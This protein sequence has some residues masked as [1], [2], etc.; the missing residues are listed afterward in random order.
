MA[1]S[2]DD[3]N[4]PSLE[5]IPLSQRRELPP[6]NSTDSH[7]QNNNSISFSS[8][9][10]IHATVKN[11]HDSCDSQVTYS[12]IQNDDLG[13]ANTSSLQQCSTIGDVSV[14]AKV[15]DS[16]ILLNSVD[17]GGN[18]TAS[19]QLDF[20][21]LKVKEEI[22]E[23]TVDDLDHVVLKERQRMLLARRLRGLPSPAFEA[24]SECLFKNIVDQTVEKENGEFSSVDGK[25]TAARDQC[26]DI[27]EGKN[28]SLSELP[29]EAPSGSS[30][31]TE[32]ARPK[33]RR[34]VISAYSQE[35]DQ[36]V[37]SEAMITHFDSQEEQ[38][39]MPI[40]N[41]GPSSSACPTSVK[42]KDEP[43]DNSEIHNV[44]ENAMGSTSIK[45]PVVKNEQEVHNDYNDDQV[46]H[47]I[48][49]DRL[50]FLMSRED[51]SLSIPISYPVSSSNFSESA[52]P[53]R[54][55]CARK[56]KKTATNSIQ[57]ALQEDA[58][59][60]LEALLGEG[61]LV[62]EI[63]LYG[64]TENDEA[65]DESLCQDS[66]SE[67][68]AVIT[69][70]FSQRNSFIKFPVI[71]AAKGSRESYCLASLISLV[72]QT[73]HLKLQ[74][75]PVEWGWCRDLQSFIFVF[76]RHNRI[77]LERPEYGYATYFFELLSGLP[78]E[79]QIK[80]LVVAMK[81]TTCSRISIIENKELTLFYN[82]RDVT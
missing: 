24:N 7:S 54:I 37:K 62:D 9:P 69:K 29:H 17:N 34:P 10:P 71:R 38:G 35:Y 16:K 72:E 70:I 49:N 31:S 79:W 55:K 5:Y 74:K 48:L 33:S 32:H 1:C 68:E 11:E 46:E 75:W 3:Q 59:G 65:L 53:S 80:R 73:R 56:R 30:L 22:C 23:G 61:V 8:T 60:L 66:F 39:V 13:V 26:H 82:N 81:L 6:S 67:F 20:P 64:E 51:C 21:T 45:L 41:N 40:N 25:I 18:G 63:K 52:E 28:T 36:I 77:V 27:P 44:I 12:N 42:I 14:T 43:W 2:D 76:H 15:E 57:T 50:K 19:F 4:S 58:P 47:M 78:V